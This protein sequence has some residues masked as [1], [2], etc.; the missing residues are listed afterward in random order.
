MAEVAGICMDIYEAS[1]SDATASQAGASSIASTRPGVL[2][3]FPV[4]LLEARAGCASMGKRLCRPDEW[5][6][7][8]S[9]DNGSAYV[10]G[11]VYDPAICNGIDTFCDCTGT[12]A[13][14]AACPY[15]H[16]YNQPAAGRDNACGASFHVMPTGS[17]SGC[18]AAHGLL[19]VN[20]NVWEVVDTEDG[21]E[22]FR[23]GAY[24][25]GDSEL[26]HRCDYDAT[27]GPSAKG[28]RCCADRGAP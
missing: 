23:G 5:F 22:H 24:N 27:W 8:C 26:L 28:F 16:C 13:G 1:R 6:A 25:C 2:P 19:D 7:A 9:G 14:L 17:F 4:T 15:P 18:T 12:C 21:L 20:G 11:S 10:Y 3:W